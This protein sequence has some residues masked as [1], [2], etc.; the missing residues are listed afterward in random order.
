MLRICVVALSASLFSIL[1]ACTAEVG[2]DE[3]WDTPNEE[4]TASAALTGSTVFFQGY[5]Y[6]SSNGVAAVERFAECGPDQVL[7]GFGGRVNSDN[8]ADV[9][10]YCRDILNDGSLSVNETTF[11]A[12]GTAEE[13][14]IR[15]SNGQVIVGLGG[16]VTSDNVNRFVARQCP[17]LASSKSIDIGQ[18]SHTST[19]SGIFS[20]EVNLDTHE[21]YS[22]T[23]KPKVVGAGA[24]MT[25][26]RDN[27][28]AVR[29]T[30]GLLR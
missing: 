19:S 25:A 15:A 24:G 7:T 20:T 9:T 5:T 27:V 18:C 21:G 13:K 29:M 12:G 2:E 28:Y 22:A 4:G 10:V 11:S 16:V 17:W 23:Q 6:R 1:G 8:F 14:S 30:I 3:Q 26:T